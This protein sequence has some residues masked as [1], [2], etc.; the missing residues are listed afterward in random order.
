MKSKGRSVALGYIQEVGS[1]G[2]DYRL[3]LESN[4]RQEIKANPYIS[5]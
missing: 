3:Y 1:I 5:G 2:L 4:G